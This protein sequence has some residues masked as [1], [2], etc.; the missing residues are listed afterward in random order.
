MNIQYVLTNGGI[1]CKVP[2]AGY[3]PTDSFQDVGGDDNV[4]GRSLAPV[5]QTIM[6]WLQEQN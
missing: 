3:S 4:S 1:L 5:N 6:S 2:P